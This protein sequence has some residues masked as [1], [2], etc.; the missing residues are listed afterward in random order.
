[1]ENEEPISIE[2]YNLEL[3]EA[4]KEIDEGEFTTYEELKKEMEEWWK[5]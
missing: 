2:Q 3:D 1:M 5:I 4:E